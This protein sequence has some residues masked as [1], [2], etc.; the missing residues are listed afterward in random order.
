[1][2]ILPSDS[3]DLRFPPV[4][5]ASPEGL[6]AIGGDLRRERLLQAYRHG[7][8]PWYNEGQPILWWSPDPR[9][10]LLP[11]ELKVSRSLKKT[12]RKGDYRVT[13]D[14]EFAAVIRAC[15]EP[16]EQSP[17]GGTWITPEMN[18]AYCHLHEQ[19]Y[20]HSVETWARGQLIGGLYGVALG[21]AFFGESMFSRR[22]DA[23]KVAFVYL[24]KQLDAWGYD[25]IDCQLPSAHL[26]SLGTKEIR[27]RDFLQILDRALSR[28]GRPGPWDLAPDIEVTLAGE[29]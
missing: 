18:E 29:T 20:A 4:E 21:A 12:L 1:M 24:V 9:A 2:F 3:D 13:F 8:F 7:I 11:S 16:R 23:S 10:I 17:E 15:A 5:L 26:T 25:F 19:G 27:R 14:T 22:V 28:P 6:L